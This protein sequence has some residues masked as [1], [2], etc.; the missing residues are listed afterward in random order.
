MRLQCKSGASF[1]LLSRLTLAAVSLAGAAQA[2]TY[3]VG[4]SQTEKE[5]SR[6][7]MA[8]LKP[9]D[10]VEVDGDATYK[11]DIHLQNGGTA[12]NPLTIRGK[13]VN[14][15]RPVISAGVGVGNGV[16]EGVGVGEG[17]C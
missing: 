11:G 2:T 7:F 14:G 9:G 12:G 10:I 3:S 13:L 1:S 17:H 16:G 15:K 5:L 8:K 4:P 6:A